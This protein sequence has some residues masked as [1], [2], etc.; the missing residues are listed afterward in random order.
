MKK[1]EAMIRPERADEVCRALEEMGCLGITVYSSSGH[2]IQG[3]VRQ[4][5][6][7]GEY[8]VDQLPKTVIMTVVA[9]EDVR[10]ATETIETMAKTDRM[11]DGKVFITP[12]ERAL[13]VRT[14]ETDEAALRPSASPSVTGGA[15]PRSKS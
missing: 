5:W 9:D 2:G 13:R 7:G 3:G 1:I 14:G 8:V 4:Q 6:R 12:V 15:T 10:E 11:G